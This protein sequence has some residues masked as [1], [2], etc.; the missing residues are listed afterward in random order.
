MILPVTAR[1]MA[2]VGPPHCG[3]QPVRPLGAV[4]LLLAACAV[5]SPRESAPLIDEVTVAALSAAAAPRMAGSIGA[6]Q[7]VR[8]VGD[9]HVIVLDREPPQLR[10][11][12][13]RGEPLW[14]GE[15]PVPASDAHGPQTIA[16][17]DSTLYVFSQGG[18]SE[19]VVRGDA[20]ALRARYVIDSRYFPFGA[21]TGCG[22]GLLLYARND[23]QL[24]PEGGTAE[25][26]FLHRVT[27]G[28]T[29]A[30]V[31]PVW[32]APQHGDR[33]HVGHSG[34]LVNRS[35]S[36]VTL[37]HRAPISQPGAAIELT[38]DG[39]PIRAREE[40]DLVRGAADVPAQSPRTR[41]NEWPAGIVALP[42]GWLMPIQR[43]LPPESADPP[44]LTE[45]FHFADGT[46]QQSMLVPGRW[47][48]MDF[49]P[50]A[51]VLLYSRFPAP[52]FVTVPITQ[53]AR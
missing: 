43:G 46:L 14:T 30:E 4:L 7:E 48:A 9:A 18:L 39:E 13:L 23:A 28:D 19:W 49:H 50:S 2:G 53:P 33:R 6:A 45:F 36:T 40:L 24:H 29:V 35:G 47:K 8:F 31:T 42:H 21:V 41:G 51:G 32:S 16:A 22:D 52:H 26:D 15:V 38:C 1:V 20:L 10:L 25:I 34:V 5:E 44:W 17:L 37:L 12:S 11:F 27:L 3:R